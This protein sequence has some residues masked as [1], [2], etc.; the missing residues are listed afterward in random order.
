[1]IWPMTDREDDPDHLDDV[2]DGCGCVELWELLSERRD[3]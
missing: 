1:M 3:E 2:P